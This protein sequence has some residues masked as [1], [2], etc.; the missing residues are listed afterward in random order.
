MYNNGLPSTRYLEHNDWDTSRPDLPYVPQVNVANEVYEA[1]ELAVHT[2]I[3]HIQQFQ[4]RNGLRIF[5][6][7][8]WAANGYRNKDF[9]YLIQFILKAFEAE[10]NMGKARLEAR[11]LEGRI[12]AYVAMCM[13]ALLEQFWN[14]NIPNELD[15][16]TL[17][18]ADHAIRDYYAYVDLIEGRGR[19]R[20]RSNG[21]DFGNNDGSRAHMS[22]IDNNMGGGFDNRYNRNGYQRAQNHGNAVRS[23]FAPESPNA[24]A[25]GPRVIGMTERYAV[26][27]RRQQQEEVVEEVKAAPATHPAFKRFGVQQ[28]PKV[29]EVTSDN[30]EI[31]VTETAEEILPG[32]EEANDEILV[33]KPSA[34][35]SHQMAFDPTLFGIKLVN[36]DG[37]VIEQVLPL[38]EINTMDRNA[39]K[40]VKGFGIQTHTREEVEKQRKALQETTAIAGVVPEEGKEPP[41]YTHYIRKNGILGT[42][43]EVLT[44]VLKADRLVVGKK[45]G[46]I[47]NIYISTVVGAKPLFGNVSCR[48]QVDRLHACTSYI[49]LGA[50]LAVLKDSFEITGDIASWYKL[51][52]MARK[53]FEEVLALSFSIYDYELENFTEDIAVALE[54]ITTRY[55]I[56]VASAI[57]ETAVS[58]IPATFNV[59]GDEHSEVVKEEYVS[60]VDD[61]D[62]WTEGVT[63][64]ENLCTVSLL[65]CTAQDLQVSWSRTNRSALVSQEYTPLLYSVADMIFNK[66]DE[67]SVYSQHFVVTEDGE[68]FKFARG[69]L[70]RDSF[71]VTLI[72]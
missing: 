23:M 38:S 28:L 34:K 35:Q 6:F 20:G 42:S 72:K 4:T 2:A 71:I 41:K 9:D 25:K 40:A 61:F 65:S 53:M 36:D 22:Y 29:V 43:V 30:Q 12:P 45:S 68:K 27:Q 63:F 1:V 5:A 19:Y 7:N 58:V 3:S 57:E 26:R 33:W 59:L 67:T 17:E 56:G 52:R 13:S 24:G 62:E 47:P 15:Q 48:T 70:K 14:T 46:E 21:F 51:E 39:H 10:V 37:D 60:L 69:G 49:Q 66:I 11:D 54:L 55:G 64:I 44:E 32:F 8:I 18:A 16:Q 31:P 50:E